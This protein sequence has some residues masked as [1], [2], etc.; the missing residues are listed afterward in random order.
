MRAEKEE[1]IPFEYFLYRI[2]DKGW[3]LEKSRHV[4]NFQEFPFGF[5]S[6]ENK[7]NYLNKALAISLPMEPWWLRCFSWQNQ[8]YFISLKTGKVIYR[9]AVDE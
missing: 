3:L 8:L 5:L 1:H 7:N 4:F 9:I 2:N 6:S